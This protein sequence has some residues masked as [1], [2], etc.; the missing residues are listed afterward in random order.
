MSYLLLYIPIC[1][2]ILT[3]LE[4]CKQDDPKK[5]ARA[6]LINSGILTGVLL[7]SSILVYALQKML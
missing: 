2:V 6:S 3:V 7:G 5:I 1:L 4:A